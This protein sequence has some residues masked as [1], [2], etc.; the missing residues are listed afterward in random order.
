MKDK[1]QKEPILR[2]PPIVLV[3]C[4][5]LIG[6]HFILFSL[7]PDISFGLVMMF[8]FV[9]A[10]L[11]ES[12]VSFLTLISYAFLHGSWEHV[13]MN[14]VWLLVFGTPVAIR[15]GGVWRFFAFYVVCALI[16]GLTHYVIYAQTL[17]PLIG[18]SGAVSGMFGAATRFAIPGVS[19]LSPDQARRQL[20]LMPLR[21]TLTRR[22]VYSFIAVWIGLN[23]VFGVSAYSLSGDPISVAWQAHIGGFLAGL[24]LLPFFE[25]PPISPSGGPGYVEYGRW[26]GS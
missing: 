25:R 23:I 15:L 19:W 12:F 6:V 18:A 2:A 17:V 7:E 3:L 9:P 13:L 1:A 26:A 20:P 4:A 16:A 11:G 22:P 5:V 14:S 21:Q 10:L 24:V 8:G